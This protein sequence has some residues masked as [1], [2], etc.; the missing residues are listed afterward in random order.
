MN[1]LRLYMYIIIIIIIVFY[2]FKIG[3]VFQIGWNILLMGTNN[4]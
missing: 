1:I 4:I 2:L 3:L